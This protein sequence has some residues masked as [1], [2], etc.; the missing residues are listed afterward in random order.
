M[1][2]ESQENL[3]AHILLSPFSQRSLLSGRKLNPSGLPRREKVGIQVNGLLRR[4]ALIAGACFGWR[5]G[6]LLCTPRFYMGSDIVNSSPPVCKP[7]SFFCK[8]SLKSQRTLLLHL[9]CYSPAM[10][11]L[12]KI[13]LVYQCST[14]PAKQTCSRDDPR[15]VNQVCL[16]RNMTK[17]WL[18]F[19][20]SALVCG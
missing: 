4:R 5:L 18:H 16:P 13:S 8:P 20:F 2:E 14:V 9:K 3:E 19:C 10:L 6:D 7:S 11:C 17:G 12:I 15:F 1:E